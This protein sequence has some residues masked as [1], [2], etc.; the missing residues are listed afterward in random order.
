MSSHG[1]GTTEYTVAS[2]MDR[3]FIQWLT[4]PDA[5]QMQVSL[6]ADITD[7]AVTSVTLGQFTI[8][9]D[10]SLL[11]QGS[12]LEA[13]QELMRV[14]DY[15]SIT[16]VVTV[17]RGAYGTPKGAHA[18]PMLLNL[19]PV[20]SRASVFE[21]VADNIL[22]LY[23]RLFT[24]TQELLSPSADMVYA[25]NDELAVSALSVTPGDFTSID[26]LG[27]RIIDFHPM[28]GGRALITDVPSA[29]VWLRYRRRMGK[30][31]SEGSAIADLGCDERW[32]T[33]VM[34]GAAGDLMAGK[35]I[36]AS[37]TE[38]VK[39]VLEAETIRVGTRMSI[40]G[41]LRQYRNMLLEDFA[42]EMRAEYKPK[43]KM[44]STAQRMP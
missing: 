6:G 25:L 14:T 8:P 43:V 20:Y 33:V 39:S 17:E 27:G 34:A 36:S 18:Q 10:E 11:R 19:N 38:W 32:I 9:E 26:D 28:I 7:D 44:R 24:V 40:G 4:P 2:V 23:P 16:K 1:A 42:K 29:T 22:T 21:A 31:T 41:G 5:Q 13:E 37:H 12:L 30:A 3:L 35:D 15:D